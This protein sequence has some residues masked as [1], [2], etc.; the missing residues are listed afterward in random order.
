MEVVLFLCIQQSLC[1]PYIGLSANTTGVVMWWAY[2][3]PNGHTSKFFEDRI[4]SY[5]ISLLRHVG[6]GKK[7]EI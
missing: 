7:V 2:P 6:Q 4:E 5:I 1:P 3:Q